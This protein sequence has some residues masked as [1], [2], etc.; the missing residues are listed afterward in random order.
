MNA[1]PEVAWIRPLGTE[2]LKPVAHLRGRFGRAVHPAAENLGMIVGLAELEPGQDTGWD[3][4][5]EPTVRRIRA[6]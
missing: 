2:T 4:H 3:V 6:A 5:P 1:T